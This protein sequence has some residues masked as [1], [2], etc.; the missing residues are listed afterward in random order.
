MHASLLDLPPELLIDILCFLPYHTLFACSGTNR[1][2]NELVASSPRVQYHLH[3]HIAGIR[4][5]ST[6][7]TSSLT[8]PDRL[9]LL[10]SRE[11]SWRTLHYS[12]TTSIP[13]PHNVSSIYDLTAGIYLLGEALRTEQRGLMAR[14]ERTRAVRYVRLP[15]LPMDGALLEWSRIDVGEEVVDIGLNVV[16]LDLIAILTR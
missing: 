5:D 3:A 10:K 12:G 2:L 9:K 16:E 11:E 7:N 4:P 1:L 13:I 14:I 8:L 6:T 15:S